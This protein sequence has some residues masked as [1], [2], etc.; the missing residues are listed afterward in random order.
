MWISIQELNEMGEYT[1]VELHQAKDVNT[2]GIFQLRQ[3]CIFSLPSYSCLNYFLNFILSFSLLSIFCLGSFSQSSGDS[4]TRAAFRNIASHGRSNS[5]SLCRW[6][7]CQINQTAKGLGQLPGK[8]VNFS[9]WCGSAVLDPAQQ[10][11]KGPWHTWY[12]ICSFTRA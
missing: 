1:A 11:Q 2:G 3:V 10:F 9:V 4:E 7:D 8:A 5:F 12:M 6:G